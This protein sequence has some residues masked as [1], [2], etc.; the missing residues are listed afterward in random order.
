MHKH[1]FFLACIFLFACNTKTRKNEPVPAPTGYDF[2]Q[3]E[4]IR[5]PQE[6]DEISG[7][8][9]DEKRGFIIALNDEQGRLFK[10]P[11]DG[12]R[13]F[14]HYRFRKGGDYEDLCLANGELWAL[15]SKGSVT[16][17][18]NPLT[19][20]MDAKHVEF[21]LRGSLNFESLVWF[22]QN[23][24]L[25]LICK[26]CTAYPGQAPGFFFDP[27]QARFDSIPR[28]RLDFSAMEAQERPDSLKPLRP[29][30]AAFHPITHE[31]FILA[32]VN[33]RLVIADS[34]GRVSRMFKLD[35]KVFKQ[36]EGICFSPNGDL[37]ISNEA[38]TGNA[39]IRKLAYR[40]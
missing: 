10:I 22:P 20:S 2:S 34:T 24:R 33:H 37:Y 32:S 14:P 6:L 12:S 17:I 39:N 31:L 35:K 18:R 30:A 28:F 38:R 21:P 7:M 27:M 5:L 8:V 40:P 13:D 29:S 16:H 11:L 23:N 4:S 15:N 26:E 3:P 36:P 25:L 1:A 9:Y 19:D